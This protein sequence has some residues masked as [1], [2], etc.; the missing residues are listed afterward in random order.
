MPGAS[1]DQ[2]TLIVRH[3]GERTTEACAQLLQALAPGQRVHR[4]T[5][6]PFHETL[7]QSLELGLAE[8]RPWTLC[9]DA[10]VLVL[11]GL[12]DFLASTD[13]FPAGFFEAQALVLDKLMPVRRPAGNHLY[14]TELLGKALPMIPLRGSLRPESD[15]IRAMAAA[16]FRD[17]QTRHLVGL[18]DFEQDYADV[19]A[20]AS[21]H[22][23][24]HRFLVPLLRPVWQSLARSDDDFRV[25]LAALDGARDRSEAP[26]VSRDFA[27]ERV[28]DALALLK[29]G[30]KA[31][32]GTIEPG[33]VKNLLLAAGAAQ[34]RPTAARVA[35]IQSKIDTAVFA[36]DS[37]AVRVDYLLSR[38]RDHLPWLNSR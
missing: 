21:L 7:R 22:A 27:A 38:L 19:Y 37:L 34:D 5:G 1:L 11:P 24:K 16:G 28:A 13:S 10:D 29:L 25:A 20:K 30:P 31:P 8:G 35:R 9:I 33:A 23:H 4:V 3:C 12:A 2:V 6:R 17:H 15:M 36:P 26:T 32:L 14:R 18:H